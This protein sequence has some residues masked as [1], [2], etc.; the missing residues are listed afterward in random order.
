[1]K[2]L[3]TVL[4]FCGLLLIP[5]TT[6]AYEAEMNGTGATDV[7]YTATELV[8]TTPVEMLTAPKTGD[9]T[10]DFTG[11]LFVISSALLVILLILYR[12]EKEEEDRI[13]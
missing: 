10:Y 13:S 4:A 6:Y 9:E 7:T 2:K 1:M 8:I 5:R 11:N 12:K 3:L